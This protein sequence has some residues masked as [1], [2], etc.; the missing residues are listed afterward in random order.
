MKKNTSLEGLQ[1]TK[2]YGVMI[3][4]SLFLLIFL[5]G[6]VSAADWD[7]IK[8]YD[9][10]TKTITI[11]SSVLWIYPLDTVAT[12]KLNTEQNQFVGAGYQEVWE[13][14]FITYEDFKPYL[15]NIELINLKDNSKITR[16]IDFKF[17]TLEE[18]E[19]NDYS[20]NKIIL[21]NGTTTEECLIEGTHLEE[22]EVWKDI[23]NYSW[24]SGEKV[25]VGAFTDVKIGDHVEWILI[26]M[27]GKKLEEW[28]SWTQ[29][30]SV[31]LAGYWSFDETGSATTFRDNTTNYQHNGTVVNKNALSWKSGANCIIGGCLDLLASNDYAYIGTSVQDGYN[32]YSDDTTTAWSLNFWIKKP[33]SGTGGDAG[34]VTK[35]NPPNSTTP[36]SFA[37][38]GTTGF[39]VRYDGEAMGWNGKPPLLVWTMQ[40]VNWNTT[41]LNWYSNGTLTN[42]TAATHYPVANDSAIIIGFYGNIGGQDGNFTID[43]MGWWNRSLSQ[44]EITQLWNGGAG[45]SYTD[46]FNS[47]NI[48]LLSPENYVNTTNSTIY[49]EGN[50]TSTVMSIT[51]V[52]L[53]IDGV[54]NQTNTSGINGTYQFSSGAAEGEHNWTMIAYGDNDI[55]YNATNGTFIFTIDSTSPTVNNDNLSNQ[56]TTSLPV[57]L[58]WN[59]SASDTH[60]SKCYYNW[61]GNATYT[62]VT[63]NSPIITSISTEGNHTFQYCANDT[64]GFESCGTGYSYVTL[65]NISQAD[66]P[67]PTGEGGT[68]TF[69]LTINTSSIP[70]TTATLFLNNTVYYP[71]TIVAGANGYFFEKEVTIPL[72]WGNSTGKNATWFWNYT[73]SGLTTNS[74]TSTQNLTIYSLSLD[75]C[76]TF[77]DVIFN[78]TLY[79]EPNATIIN[80]TAGSNIQ[81]D[82]TLTSRS[83]SSIY[84]NINQTISNNATSSICVPTGLLSGGS[85]Y[86]IDIVS[87]YSATDHVI[88]FFYLDNGTLNSSSFLDSLTNRTIRVYDLPSADSTTF[89]FSFLDEDNV[90]VPNAIVHVF[91]QYIGSGVFREVERGKQ[92]NNGETHLHLVEE[93]VIYFFKISLNGD[94]L[95]T[96]T[97]YNAKCLSSPC[98]IELSGAIGNPTFDTNFTGIDGSYEVT[99]F[100]SQRIVMLQ[101]ALNDPATMNLSL[102]KQDYT[103]NLTIV[104]TT[105][106]TSTGS[107]LNLTIPQAA[108]NVTFYAIVYKDGQFVAYRV[109][110]LQ[111]AGYD[112]F[113]TTGLI[114]ASMLILALVLMAIFEGA[115]VI[116][117]LILALAISGAMKIIN[118]GYYSLIGLICALIILIF[119]LVQKRR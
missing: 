19:I 30:L 5:V 80:A 39:Y 86:R 57:N 104:N 101:F 45:I 27:F 67:D 91:R 102:A 65:A 82:L 58:T 78:M 21:K 92:D 11:K 76:S 89:L 63:C 116:V 107:S 18:V 16:Q 53:L 31:G 44:S 68:V 59:Y 98:Q 14:E 47:L 106:V 17:K 32:D 51:N 60:L 3:M 43:E 6:S 85:E 110:N 25:I 109:L 81:I 36:F 112:Y 100:S 97:T 9:S 93:D 26:D 83:D 48:D 103:G 73:I 40:T 23:K 108:G 28:A 115:G 55:Q 54:I 38:D 66:N 114:M 77:G 2:R 1:S 75:N 90:E 4:I 117:F 111:N 79:D 105:S 74:S 113:G 99:T 10:Q 15:S 52:S 37:G 12:I 56:F 22:R 70:T 50:I 88:E 72:G 119:K 24:K 29:A 33:A 96:S 7:N 118:L 20:C 62:N 95:F 41:H 34:F 42:S 49:F 61:T 94:L 13:Q 35:N 87:Q 46:V 69:N 8:S 84:K 71:D 64:F